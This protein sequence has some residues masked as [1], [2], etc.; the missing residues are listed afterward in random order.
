[1]ETWICFTACGP[2]TSG[3]LNILL[4]DWYRTWVADW[5]ALPISGFR[6][7]LAGFYSGLGVYFSTF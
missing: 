4:N 1:M 3:N 7:A 6:L 2:H 5:G